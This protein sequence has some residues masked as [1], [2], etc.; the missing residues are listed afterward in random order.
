M[1]WLLPEGYEV[2]PGRGSPGVTV[3][4]ARRARA[5]LLET[6]LERPEEAAAGPA[7]A[8][9]V[10]GG[11]VRHPV[12]RAG[13]ERWLLKAYRRGGL[14]RRLNPDRYWRTGRF[15]RE[16]WTAVAAAR[17]GV[18]A[19]EPIAL[20][21]RA[22][23]WGGAHRAWQ[24]VRYVPGVFSLR[25]ILDGRAPAGLRARSL[26]G[27]FRAAGS[28]VRKM[29][30]AHID[31]PDLNLGNI[32]AR[33][34]GVNGAE[35]GAKEPGQSQAFPEAFIVDWDRARLRHR[36]SW[37][38]HRNLLRLWRSALKLARLSRPPVVPDPAALRAFLRG[39]FGRDRSD[40]RALRGY[41]RPRRPLIALHAALW[42]V[43]RRGKL[44]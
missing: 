34:S 20:I 21:L 7:V 35:N 32:L 25:E 4:V 44:S 43:E 13:E 1:A 3:V 24:V 9:W 28:A 23:G 26:T 39:Y 12:I 8:A 37:N 40:L 30:E 27:I 17:A 16:L 22:A 38:P 18:P 5:A 31:H 29:H 33:V 11:R 41:L 42:E 6:G 36:G 19:P 2:F 15:V 10:G 14:F